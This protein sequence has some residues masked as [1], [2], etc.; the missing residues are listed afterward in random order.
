M[1]D[2]TV[3]CDN[4][5]AEAWVSVEIA[6]L[7]SDA[8]VGFDTPEGAHK[9]EAPRLDFCYHHYNKHSLLLHAEGWIVTNDERD[10]INVKPSVSV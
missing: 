8:W 9:V 5:G 4:C 3:R 2:K 7:D 10:S 1:Q 6:N